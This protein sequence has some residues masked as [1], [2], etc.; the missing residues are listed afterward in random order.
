MYLATLF[1]YGP[2]LYHIRQS[3]FDRD[4]QR[5]RFRCVFDL[6]EDPTVYFELLDGEI[7]AFDSKLVNALECSGCKDADAM[8]EDLLWPFFPVDTRRRL[9]RFRRSGASRLKPLSDEEKEEID[10]TIHIFDRRR[11]Y[12]LYYRAVDQSRLYRMHEKLCRPL[13]GCCRDEREYIFMDMESQLRSREYHT[14][15]YAIFNLQQHFDLSFAAWLPPAHLYEKIGELF[16][17]E[18]CVLNSSRS[19]TGDAA[20]AA[21][22]YHHLRRYLVMFFDYMPSWQHSPAQEYVRNFM[23]N[24]RK[25]RWPEKEPEVA[26][27]QANKYFSVSYQELKKMDKKELTRLFRK[28]AKELHPDK[29]GEHEAFVELMQLYTALLKSKK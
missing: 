6:G 10:R 14:Y 3:F 28:K 24:H 8:L 11:L 2:P 9:S 5:Y 20:S 26:K 16:E 21:S 1:Q 19:F 25:F 12:Y 15:V 23:N 27:E 22:L 4:A 13:L 18:I 17:Q 29:G 7:P